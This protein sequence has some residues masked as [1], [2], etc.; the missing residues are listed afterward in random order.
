MNN[1]N[2]PGLKLCLF[3]NEPLVYKLLIGLSI[4]SV[5]ALRYLLH[6]PVNACICICMCVGCGIICTQL[7]LDNCPIHLLT[8]RYT[9]LL[10]WHSMMLLAFVVV[11]FIV[12]IVAA[13]IALVV[14][15]IALRLNLLRTIN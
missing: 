7:S 14:V 15:V 2:I 11:V 1:F 5:N 12:A 10:Q 9:V 4:F 13:I 8:S 3:E 6:I